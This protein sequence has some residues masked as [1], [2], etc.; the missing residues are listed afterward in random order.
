MCRSILAA[1][2]AVLFAAS[3]GHDD[4]PMTRAEFC[5]SYGERECSNVVPA[6]LVP[7]ADCESVRQAWCMAWGQSEEDAQPPRP[8][9]P[10]NAD[11][12]LSKVSAVFGVIKNNMAIQAS[13]FRS[14]DQACARVFHGIGQANESCGI[15]A[16]CSGSLICDKGR[17]G[18][19]HQVD[20]GA[21]CAN[22][23]ES[24][25]PGYT[26]GGETGV[27]M[28]EVRPGLDAACDG[29]PCLE[30]LRCDSGVCV[31]RLLTGTACQSDGD[32]ESRFCEP[33]ALRCGADVRFANG[34]AACQAYQSGGS[35]G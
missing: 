6:C 33:F 19:L 26:C 13:D 3:C 12:C 35:G 16:D 8:F 27:L 7:D 28:C 29:V 30:E 21:G 23:G 18:T 5:R 4:A 31:A 32:C 14:I 10:Q 9:D 1:T 25:P 22:I 17:C 34:T 11:A 15:D 20:P 2:L 24:C